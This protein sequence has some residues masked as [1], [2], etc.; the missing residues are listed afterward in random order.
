V[1]KS[2]AVPL[3]RGGYARD[4]CR[5]EAHSDDVHASQA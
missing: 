3:N 2:L 1:C 4:V 5:V